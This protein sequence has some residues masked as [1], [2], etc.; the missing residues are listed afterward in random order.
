MSCWVR[1]DWREL[2]ASVR[3]ARLFV[4]SVVTKNLHVGAITLVFSILLNPEVFE[5]MPLKEGRI[6]METIVLEKF[7]LELTGFGDGG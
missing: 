1:W 4:G 7:F 5:Y 6:G 3:E 2:D